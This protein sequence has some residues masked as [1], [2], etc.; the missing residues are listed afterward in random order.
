MEEVL[1]LGKDPF[2]KIL[3]KLRLASSQG[4]WVEVV[5]NGKIGS[6]CNHM[7]AERYFRILQVVLKFERDGKK[8]YSLESFEGTQIRFLDLRSS[9]D[10]EAARLNLMRIANQN[11]FENFVRRRE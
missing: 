9:F 7:P 2:I 1:I 6:Y 4:L 11:Y 8:L 5:S 3:K 10:L